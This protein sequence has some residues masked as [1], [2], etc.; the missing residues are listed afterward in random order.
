MKLLEP[1]DEHRLYLADL[2]AWRAYKQIKHCADDSERRRIWKTL[3]PEIKA[4]ISEAY[5][6]E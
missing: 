2:P 6:D 5:A 3:K 4:K 1:I